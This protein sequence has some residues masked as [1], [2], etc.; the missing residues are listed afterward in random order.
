MNYSEIFD[1]LIFGALFGGLAG[2]YVSR[3][4]FKTDSKTN[5][6]RGVNDATEIFLAFIARTSNE[7]E[8]SGT[9]IGQPDAR[10]SEAGAARIDSQT[11]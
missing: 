9:P 10:D 1:A 11:V 7:T 4:Y 3:L 6:L 5:Y 2:S 8:Q